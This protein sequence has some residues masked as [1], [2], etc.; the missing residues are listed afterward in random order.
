M[1]IF[2]WHWWRKNT[3]LFTKM[4]WTCIFFQVLK[5]C[6]ITSFS[7]KQRAA[8]LSKSATQHNPLIHCLIEKLGTALVSPRIQ[9]APSTATSPLTSSLPSHGRVECFS[10]LLLLCIFRKHH[11][12]L[13]SS[14]SRSEQ[15]PLSTATPNALSPYLFTL[16]SLLSKQLQ[17][18]GVSARYTFTTNIRWNAKQ[19]FLNTTHLH[20][21]LYNKIHDL[22]I[23]FYLAARNY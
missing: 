9:P 5:D 16:S 18:S 3:F 23:D 21:S 11:L 20:L 22:L 17:R 12:P 1:S 4:S 15:W 8:P 19:Y 10:A 13:A 2:I 7:L 6:C 14:F